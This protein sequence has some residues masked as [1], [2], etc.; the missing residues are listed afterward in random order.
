[1]STNEAKNR[2]QTLPYLRALLT[3]STPFYNPKNTQENTLPAP[4]PKK[5]LHKHEH[6]YAQH[7]PSINNYNLQQKK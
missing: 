2:A 1:M 7:N 3:H 4:I 5:R 6:K